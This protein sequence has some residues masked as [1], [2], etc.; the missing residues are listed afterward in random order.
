MATFE[1]Q[2]AGHE[3]SML[4]S[5]KDKLLKPVSKNEMLFYQTYYDKIPGFTE[6]APTFFGTLEKEDKSNSNFTFNKNRVHHSRRSYSS[7]HET[8]HT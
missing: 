4:K 2:T 5:G 6:F 7:F 3:G 8:V 1:H